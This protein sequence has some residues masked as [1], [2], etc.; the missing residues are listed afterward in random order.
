MLTKKKYLGLGIIVLLLSACHL[1]TNK[2]MS[3]EKTNRTPALYNSI[4]QQ[5]LS[6][7]HYPIF[8]N[9]STLNTND[10]L[11]GKDTYII[12]GLIQT[13]TLE[14][15]KKQTISLSKEMDPQGLAI[16]EDYLIISAYSHDHTHNSV[17]Y[18]LDK[19][20]HK[21]LKTIVLPGKPHVGG[22]AYDPKS[23]KLWLCAKSDSGKAAIAAINLKTIE[24]YRLRPNKLPIPYSQEITLNQIKRASFMTY[25]DN[26]LYVGYFSK[27]HES[28]ID[29]YA[30]DDAGMIQKTAQ[31]SILLRTKK[32]ELQASDFIDIEHGIQGITFYNE[33]ALL[34]QSYGAQNSH[35]L[36]YH[37]KNNSN[38]RYLDQEL[39]LTI[40]APPY[41]EQITTDNKQLLTLFE[42]G[43]KRFRSQ[44]DVTKVDRVIP[45]NL[46]R[47]LEPLHNKKE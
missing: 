12:P 25:N 13:E 40:E 34:S 6:L 21:Y 19:K 45:L 22:L 31:N 14:I 11:K 43:S 17:L 18:L 39:L 7:K 15:N 36:V 20:S 10:L 47:L 2:E 29:E 44:P 42:S 28:I 46:E 30:L 24:D 35:I 3:V 38:V 1:T 32:S 4:N 41:L 23:K 27:K 8:F 37:K 16:T 33:Y 26:K 9:A 5:I